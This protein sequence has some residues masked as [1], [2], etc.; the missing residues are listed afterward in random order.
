MMSTAGSSR[1]ICVPAA[2]YSLPMPRAL[3]QVAH[4]MLPTN[5]R[6]SASKRP[7]AAKLRLNTLTTGMPCTNST[8]VPLSF[9]RLCAMARWHAAPS[10]LPSAL[11]SRRNETTMGTTSSNASRQSTNAR[12]AMVSSG[13]ATA[14]TVSERLWAMNPSIFSTSSLSTFLI[15]PWRTW[16]K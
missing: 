9:S 11:P 16:L 5:S 13:R 2:A 10:G 6:A 12:A 7:N 8:V 4:L 3:N 14:H 1:S 15:S